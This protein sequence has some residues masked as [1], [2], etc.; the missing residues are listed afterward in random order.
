MFTVE[1]KS[2]AEA[3]AAV[4]KWVVTPDTTLMSLTGTVMSDRAPLDISDGGA[5]S[6]GTKAQPPMLPEPA[7][8]P[9]VVVTEPESE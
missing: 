8:A 9:P 1:A 6:S 7:P 4:A 2:M 5:V 3:E